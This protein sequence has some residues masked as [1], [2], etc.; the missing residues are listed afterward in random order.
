M[1][2]TPI[3]D[4]IMK[5]ISEKNNLFCTPG[6]KGGRGFAN[7]EGGRSLYENIIKI[8]LTEVD[9]LD[10]LHD[11]QGII[12]ESEERLRDLYESKKSY[13]LVNG[14]TSGNLAMIFSCFNEGDKVIVERNCHKSIFNGIILRKLNPVYIKNYFDEDINAPLSIDEEYFFQDYKRKY[15]CKRDNTYIS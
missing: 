8:D 9:G 5:Y 7:S 3:I 14:S 15:G 6:H 4:G 10:N 1:S 11:P 2:K 13:F 12:K